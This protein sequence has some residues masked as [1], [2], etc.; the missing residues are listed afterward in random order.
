MN[1]REFLGVSMV[2]SSMALV[3]PFAHA[4]NL[5]INEAINKS[6]RQRML[7]QRIGKAYLQIGQGIDLR[8][9]EQIFTDSLN[10]FE[11]Q[12]SELTTFAPSVE[13]KATLLE[14]G[15]SWRRYKDVLQD[16][17]PNKTDA[18]AVM[19]LSDEVLALTQTAT[20]QLEKISGTTS[21]RLVNLSGRQRMLSQRMAKLYQ[22]M[23]WE[24]PTSDVLQKLV[25][26]RTEFMRAMQELVAAPVNTEAIKR[27]LDLAD[28]QWFFFDQALKNRVTDQNDRLRAATNVATTSERIL[29]TMNRITGMYEK[30]T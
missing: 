1:R 10:L 2:A 6:G 4:Q 13:N 11:L 29:E 27:E 15:K 3:F 24:V 28:Q 17:A 5:S 19:L 22:S 8:R 7:S 14:V 9:S 25:T 16:R 30:L 23:S 12:L 18:Q 21:A 20:V 26:A